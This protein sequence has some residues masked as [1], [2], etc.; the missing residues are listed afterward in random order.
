MVDA[1]YGTE[2]GRTLVCPQCKT[3]FRQHMRQLVFG[4]M[5]APSSGPLPRE[6]S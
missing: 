3:N 4:D 2:S 6:G 5:D 1:D